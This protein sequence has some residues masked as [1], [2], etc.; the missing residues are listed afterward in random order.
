MARS[1]SL[2]NKCQLLFGGAVVLIVIAALIGPWLR[3]G[4]VIDQSE[5][6]ALRDLA[7]AQTDGSEDLSLRRLTVGAADA[8]ENEFAARAL[9]RFT[10]DPALAEHVET[11]WDE[12]VRVFRYARPV[13]DEAGA[14]ESLVLIERRSPRVAGRL[15]INRLFLLSA[16]LLAGGLAVL[17]FY[18]IT[19]RLILSPV[20]SLK[21]TAEQIMAGDPAARA[22]IRTGDEFEQLAD[23]FNGMLAGL[24]EKRDQ[25]RA[26]NQS[27]DL[28]VARLE[29]ANLAL[30]E[31]ATLKGDFIAAVSHELRTPLN[32][33]IGFAELLQEI[34]QRDRAAGLVRDEEEWLKRQRYLDHIVESGRSLLE[35]INELLD[36]AK[37]EAGKMDLHVEL[38]S[39]DEACDGLLALIR[40]QAERKGVA[41]QYD[42]AGLRAEADGAAPI[43]E[44]DPRKF[45]QIVFNFLSNAVKFTPEGGRVTLRAERLVAGD[46]EPRVRVS[47]IDTGPG[48]APEDQGRI[49][50]KFTQLATGHTR[51]HSGTGLGLAIARELTGMIQG[52]IQLESAVGRGSMF[53]LIVPF[54]MDPELAASRALRLSGREPAPEPHADEAAGLSARA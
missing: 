27:L 21:H 24:E 37:I 17:V 5:I 13:R 34:A 44:T 23:A 54:R 16:G 45:Q 46:G 26:A 35:M 3:V 25:L 33:I 22:D 40:P 42:A 12:G 51:L 29:E 8:V 6:G 30:H 19:T 18:L 14:V 32:S 20:R 52:D 15:F 10:A 41:L 48:I 39:V 2:A 11:M 4:A 1:V 36:M 9:E 53:S 43:I 31:A 28:R 7:L 50:E 49:F 38:M 47:V